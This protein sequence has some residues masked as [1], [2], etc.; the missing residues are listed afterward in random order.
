MAPSRGFMWSYSLLDI[1]QSFWKRKIVETSIEGLAE[2]LVDYPPPSNWGNIAVDSV[3]TVETRLE[4]AT[5][6]LQLE[7]EPKEERVQIRSYH[8]REIGRETNEISCNFSNSGVMTEFI[9]DSEE[10]C[11][12]MFLCGDWNDFEPIPMIAASDNGEQSVI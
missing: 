11:S 8:S 4:D 7:T 1:L 3:H 5:G 12:Q 9:F 10:C 6:N 2:G